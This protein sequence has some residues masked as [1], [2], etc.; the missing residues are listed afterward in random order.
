MEKPNN[1]NAFCSKKDCPEYIRWSFGLGECDSCKKVGQSYNIYEYPD[2]CLF[3]DEIKAYE[4]GENVVIITDND[5][6]NAINKQ[7]ND[8]G[9]GTI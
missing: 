4:L 9:Y 3:I 1:F 5:A 6:I 8:N 7:L 2:D